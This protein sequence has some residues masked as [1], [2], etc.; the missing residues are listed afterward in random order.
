MDLLHFA[1]LRGSFV[2]ILWSLNKCQRVAIKQK[3]KRPGQPC[4]ALLWKSGAP[5]AAIWVSFVRPVKVC[6]QKYGALLHFN[7]CL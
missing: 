7:K 6:L 3:N 1:F 5:L 4:S 2:K